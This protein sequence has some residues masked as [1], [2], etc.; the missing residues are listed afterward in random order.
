MTPTDLLCAGKNAAGLPCQQHVKR[1]GGYCGQHRQKTTDL[2]IRSLKEAVDETHVLRSRNDI[3]AGLIK[4]F[5][6]LLDRR[7]VDQPYFF[8]DVCHTRECPGWRIGSSYKP[9]NCGAEDIR[10]VW[11]ELLSSMR[12]SQKC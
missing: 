12:R 3:L 5:L 2:A 1:P 9:C 10:T 7:G 8:T 4:E 11:R 6:L